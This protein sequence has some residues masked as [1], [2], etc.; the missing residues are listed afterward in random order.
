MKVQELIKQLKKLP[1][2]MQ[3]YTDF[4]LS[5]GDGDACLPVNFAALVRVSNAEQTFDA[6]MLT[7]YWRDNPEKES[8]PTSGDYCIDSDLLQRVGIEYRKDNRDALTEDAFAAGAGWAVKVLADRKKDIV[9]DVM[10]L[11][12]RGKISTITPNERILTMLGK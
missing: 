6:A 1:A 5:A 4:G 2:D 11:L 8:F 3:V 12:R 9:C 10:Q 7:A